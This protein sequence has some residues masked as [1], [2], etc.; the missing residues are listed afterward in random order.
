MRLLHLAV[1][2]S[3]L[4]ACT[5]AQRLPDIPCEG[6]CPTGQSCDRAIGECRA[7][8]CEGRC[9]KWERCVGMD[10]QAHCETIPS[11]TTG[12]SRPD[13]SALPSSVY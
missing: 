6:T 8:S 3:A 12:P 11:P 10:T 1:L 7:D 4:C 2:L 9:T 13:T 5:H